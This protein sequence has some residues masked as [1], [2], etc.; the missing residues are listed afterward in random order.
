MLEVSKQFLED[1]CI[2]MPFWALLLNKMCSLTFLD[3]TERYC[4]KTVRKQKY[5]CYACSP[6]KGFDFSGPT[7]YSPEP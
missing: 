3:T 6:V 1:R 7:I 5:L 4:W 2:V